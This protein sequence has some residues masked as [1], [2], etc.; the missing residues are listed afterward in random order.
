M[1]SQIEKKLYNLPKVKFSRVADLKL[2]WRLYILIWQKSFKRLL[3]LL[4]LR[5]LSFAFTAGFVFLCLIVI[6]PG[7]AYASPD[8]TRGHFLYPVKKIIESAEL[9]MNYTPIAKINTLEKFA[10]RRLAETIV[11]NQKDINSNKKEADLQS[12]L[13]EAVAL[14]TQASKQAETILN[15]P[16][17]AKAEMIISEARKT[18][19]GLLNN[20]AGGVGLKAS[21]D[22][23]DSIALAFEE[24]KSVAQEPVNKKLEENIILKNHDI[25]NNNDT[26]VATTTS[27]TTTI[28]RKEFTGQ[29]YQKNIKLSKPEIKDRISGT[30]TD[31]EENNSENETK[32]INDDWPQTQAIK[33]NIKNLKDNLKTENYNLEDIKALGDNLDNKITRAEKARDEG[34]FKEAGEILKKTEALSNN[35]EYFLKKSLKNTNQLKID[36]NKIDGSLENNTEKNDKDNSRAKRNDQND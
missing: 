26:K 35:A 9:K 16:E 24:I 2:R 17:Q 32:L 19:Q 13:K 25:I 10:S 3:A 34:R 31:A 29:K 12:S 36:N 28:I 20:L 23:L 6:L 1:K 30:S 4:E 5:R 11:L 18:H 33:N 7:Y 27:A 14:T 8:V 15:Q 21:E 22:M